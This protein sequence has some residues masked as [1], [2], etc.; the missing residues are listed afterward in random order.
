MSASPTPSFLTR[1]LSSRAPSAAVEVDA[2]RVTAVEEGMITLRQSAV[3][4]ALA[5]Q[6]T[7]KEINKVTFIE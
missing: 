5:G 1:W 4:T 6:T 7:L 3:A 2:R